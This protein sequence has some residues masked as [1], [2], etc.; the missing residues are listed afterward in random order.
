MASSIVLVLAGV[1]LLL[2]IIEL[3]RSE[4]RS[5]G[6]WAIVLLAFAVLVTRLS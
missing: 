5:V 3:F 2:G 1:S 6:A 4:A